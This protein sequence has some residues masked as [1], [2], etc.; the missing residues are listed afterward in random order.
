MSEDLFEYIDVELNK[1]KCKTCEWCYI[2]K[3]IRHP[4]DKRFYF[5]SKEDVQIK[6]NDPACNDHIEGKPKEVIYSG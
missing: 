4:Y 2:K 1:K 6:A 3:Y 5:C